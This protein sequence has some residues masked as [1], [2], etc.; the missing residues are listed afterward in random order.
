MHP[1]IDLFRHRGLFLGSTGD[2]CVHRI[3]RRDQLDSVAQ[4]LTRLSA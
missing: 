4:E 2:L 1:A 3:D